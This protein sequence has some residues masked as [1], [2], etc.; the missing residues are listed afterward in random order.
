MGICTTVGLFAGGYAP[1]L[2][3]ASAFSLQSL[4]FG[5]VGGLAGVWAGK[6]LTDV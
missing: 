4:L 6:R 2:W 1:E 5:V 3:G